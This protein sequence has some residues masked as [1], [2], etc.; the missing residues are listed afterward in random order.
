M[1]RPV[2]L[3]LHLVTVL[4][5]AGLTWSVP[6]AQA[7]GTPAGTTLTNTGTVTYDPLE[8]GGPNRTDSNVVSAVVQ[9][10]CA[11]S[12][13]PNGTLAAPGQTA[14]VLPG[15]TATFRYTLVNAGNAPATLDVTGR[16][17][18]GSAA[19]PGVRVYQD[20]N[21]NGV[22]DAADTEVSSVTLSADASAS[23]LVLV[24][25]GAGMRGDA[26]INLIGACRG[27]SA[28]Q[29]DD[30]VSRV[31]V[32]EPPLLTVGKRFTPALVRPG[33]STTVQVTATNT[34]LGASRELIL[35][36]LLAD[37][38]AL[39]L[40]FV[41]GTLQVSGAP[42][43]VLEYTA[44]GATWS[45]A[46]P[47]VVRGV[48][49]RLPSL[50]AGGQV[51]LSF[52]MLAGAQAENH[53]IPNVATATTG[54][55]T[56]TGTASADVRYLP[57]VAIGP[58]GQ[59]EVPEGS[60][61]DRQTKPFA[62]VGQPVCFD[63]TL[64]NTGDVRDAF[65]V[66]VTATQ[67][68]AQASVLAGDGTPLAQ[69]V[70]LE[71]GATTLVRVCYDAQQAGPL[72][73]E[74]T[75]TGARGTHNATVDT[76]QS[77]AAGLP[78]MRKSASTAPGAAVAAGEFV[79]YT[80]QVTNPYAQALTGVTI[81]DPLPAH[82]S[83]AEASGGGQV[84]GAAGAQSVTWTL[85]TLQ[86]G[87]TRTQT[88]KVLV[89]PNA[90]DGEDLK[91][92]YLL[93]SAELPVP[94]P[95][96]EVITPVWSAALLVT[97]VVSARSATYGDRLVYT[98]RVRNQSTTT[99]VVN[100]VVTDTP[101]PGLQYLPGTSTLGGAPTADPVS[102]AGH[103][104]WTVDRIGPGEEV[105]ITY[106]MRVTAVAT[107]D[108]GNTVQVVATGAGTTARAIASN[109]AQAVALLD[110]LHF[111][112][113][114]DVVGLVFVDRNGNGV[115]DAGDTPVERARVIMAGGRA[116]LTDTQGR[117]AFPNVAYGTQA[118]R[119]D[120]NSVALQPRR[121]PISGALP[122]TQTV[123]VRGLT[124]VDFPL[125]PQ[126]A[127]LSA[128]RRTVLTVGDV[129]VAKVVVPVPGGY[130]VTLSITSPRVIEGFDLRDP[131]PA[132]A[133]LTDGRP[134]FSGTLRA[135]ETT[136]IYRF[137]GV[138]EDRAATTDPTVSWRN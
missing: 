96:N 5:T 83:F 121:L 133:R 24:S 28:A 44:D 94:V 52:E 115:F 89:T 131:L 64:K 46:E 74:V 124:S 68:G 123:V 62:V 19:T 67:G 82:T 27:A 17:E 107:G 61:E 81:T 8:P 92:T 20:L 15:E 60:A 73:A 31:T 105:V 23:L 41:P 76:V 93:R 86:P 87:E 54:T 104:T 29:D 33:T 51:T 49:V 59:P 36:D 7:V 111:A 128:L 16:V 21:A 138:T 91:N 80:L 90:V 9:A 106:A 4:L 18:T 99:A 126:P 134:N 113:V 53:V 137:D 3:S 69:P 22:V 43:G 63:H 110:A 130:Q 101:V 100:A 34:G 136:L 129:R 127:E 57:A 42:G 11:V 109:R 125:A 95:S 48:R 65:R 50:A 84:S 66:S 117:Y 39:G 70:T 118:F 6:P 119:L 14:S 122:G 12:V 114:A 103:L 98:L 135:G 97:K 88:V 85:G 26:F 38:L 102:A 45:A 35:S 25:T 2:K 120:P 78:D 58:L 108:L 1:S 71:P 55:T 40:A 112:P 37:Q 132:G 77:V 30:N 79:T 75:A 72:S 10:V 116:A 32:G 47:A 13:T 56:V